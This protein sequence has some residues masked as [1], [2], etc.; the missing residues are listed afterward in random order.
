MALLLLSYI[1]G[2]CCQIT[3]QEVAGLTV[4]SFDYSDE[5]EKRGWYLLFI[6]FWT[7]QFIV[8]MGQIIVALT[9]VKYYF[10]KDVESV[11]EH[12]PLSFFLLGWWSRF[13]PQA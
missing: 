5:V 3:T 13:P 6:F 2:V 4:R 7:T 11:R 10:T 9:V 8:A 1:Y 12:T